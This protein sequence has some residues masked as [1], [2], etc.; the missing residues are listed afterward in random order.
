MLVGRSTG[1]RSCE[2][3]QFSTLAMKGKVTVQA[4]IVAMKEITGNTVIMI[5]VTAVI[6]FLLPY[7][8]E[9]TT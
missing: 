8:R 2:A 9:E 4:T 1:K 6:A 5:L 3:Q 7:H